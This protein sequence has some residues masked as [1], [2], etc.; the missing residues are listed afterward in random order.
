MYFFFIWILSLLPPC[1]PQKN[2]L[3]KCSNCHR[4]N[5]TEVA[6]KCS[7]LLLSVHSAVTYFYCFIITTGF[8]E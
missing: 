2:K 1:P 5:D 8:L 3:E 4:K 7:K 6:G